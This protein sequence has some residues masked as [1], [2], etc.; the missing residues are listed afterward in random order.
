MAAKLVYVMACSMADWLVAETVA[1]RDERKVDD[2]VGAKVLKSGP[3]TAVSLV[4]GSV[5]W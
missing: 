1:W 4:V 3:M 2:L 5:A